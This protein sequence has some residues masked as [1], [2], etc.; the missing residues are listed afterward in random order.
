M[1]YLYKCCSIL[2]L[3]GNI[4]ITAARDVEGGSKISA[5]LECKRV[6]T[7]LGISPP[8]GLEKAIC[9]K[10]SVI[11]GENLLIPLTPE[12]AIDQRDALAKYIYG[13]TMYDINI[14]Y[15]LHEQFLDTYQMMLLFKHYY[16]FVIVLLGRLFEYIVLRVNN[17]L[18]RGKPG[19]SIGVL[20]IFGFEVFALVNHI[21]M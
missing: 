7:L 1:E 9:N 3:L 16:H 19:P 4:N 14:Q 13:S 5:P 20:D 6:A 18:Y 2:S 21:I 11:N 15:I 10:S 8:E 12:K 17:S